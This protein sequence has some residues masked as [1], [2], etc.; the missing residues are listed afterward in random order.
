MKFII[1]VG[2]PEEMAELK[3]IE[4]VIQ[5]MGELVVGVNPVYREMLAVN[6]IFHRPG[7]KFEFC[8]S[9]KEAATEFGNRAA[10]IG[11][12]YP[13]LIESNIRSIE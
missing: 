5:E 7:F 2:S 13:H 11:L 6:E 9:T 8:L 10:A 1:N 4:R 3:A 12:I